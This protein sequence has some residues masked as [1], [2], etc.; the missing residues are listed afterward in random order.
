MS[1]KNET[2]IENR[3]ALILGQ[4]P[5]IPP[6]QTEEAIAA[7]REQTTRLKAATT[8]D[9]TLVDVSEIP[10]MLL[11][12]ICHPGL[13]EKFSALSMQMMGQSSTLSPRDREL[14]ILRTG[15][16]CQAPYEFGEHVSIAKAV[17]INSEEV[18]RVTVGSAAPG[19]NA[20]ERAVLRAA[21]ELHEDAMISE[22]TWA[23][24]ARTLEHNQLFE[25]PVLIGQFTSVA[26]FQNSL[27]FRLSAGNQGLRAR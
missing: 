25:L 19:W 13:Y 2:A 24:L 12:L 27:R 4:P 10:E 1:E 15:W 20:H 8:G 11:T 17:G 3:E 5:R 23:E 6:M 26:Y 16:L 21:E 14:A 18:E 22:D 7:A 9:T